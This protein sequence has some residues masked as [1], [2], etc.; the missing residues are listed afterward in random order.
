MTLWDQRLPVDRL[1]DRLAHARVLQRIARERPALPVG[2]EGRGVALR[3]HVQIDQAVGD[4]A[5]E[6]EPLVLLQ[7]R[8]T[9]VVGTFSIAC[10]SPASSAATRGASEGRS[11]SVTRSHGVLPP[12]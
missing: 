11:R 9:S 2:Y 4:R 12:Q 7:S 3:I 1:G 8:A 10:T 5:G 6:R